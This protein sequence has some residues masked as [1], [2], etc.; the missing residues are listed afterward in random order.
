M[1][2]RTLGV[3]ISYRQDRDDTPQQIDF[4]KTKGQG[5]HFVFVR[6]SEGIRTDPD[7]HYNWREAKEAGLLRSAYHILDYRPTARSAAMQAMHFA[8][9]LGSDRAELPPTLQVFRVMEWPE[10]LPPSDELFELIKQ[11][12]DLFEK[13]YGVKPLFYTNPGTLVYHLIETVPDWLKEHGLWITHPFRDD[14]ESRKPKISPWGTWTFWQYTESQDG[15]AYGMENKMIFLDYFNG[16]V[17][18]LQRYAEGGPG[19]GE[20]DGEDDAELTHLQKLEIMWNAN[21]DLHPS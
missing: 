2:E 8:D 15:L 20:T 6:T 10:M 7:F 13:A 19:P 21:P 5:V 9:L 11:F 17:E 4:S 16:S 3:T 14:F 1:C 18:N 12:M